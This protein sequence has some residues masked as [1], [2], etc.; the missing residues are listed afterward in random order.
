MFDFLVITST[1]YPGMLDGYIRQHYPRYEIAYPTQGQAHIVIYGRPGWYM[2]RAGIDEHFFELLFK[3]GI[4]GGWRRRW[5][6]S[7]DTRWDSPDKT[8]R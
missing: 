6:L 4:I 5:R 3:S 8:T 2:N 7:G 1:S